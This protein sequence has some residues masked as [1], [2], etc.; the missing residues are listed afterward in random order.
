MPSRYQNIILFAI[1]LSVLA[2][3]LSVYTLF[4]LHQFEVA[5]VAN[6]RSR[7]PNLFPP[8]APGCTGESCVFGDRLNE[9]IMCGDIPC[10]VEESK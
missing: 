1:G 7:F 2:V 9:T 5:V 6:E 10:W 8:Q 4:E 3:V